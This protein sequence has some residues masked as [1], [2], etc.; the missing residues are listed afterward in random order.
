MWFC[1]YDYW[2]I[3]TMARKLSVTTSILSLAKDSFTII[4]IFY[5]NQYFLHLSVVDVEFFANF[6]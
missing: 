5:F 6:I 4:I 3:E 2:T 1:L